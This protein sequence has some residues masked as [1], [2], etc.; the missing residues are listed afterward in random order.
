MRIE[1]CQL[2]GGSTK[3]KVLDL[4]EG[5]GSDISLM[6]SWDTCTAAVQAACRRAHEVVAFAKDNL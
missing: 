2:A 5:W 3:R 6:P 1:V 4:Y